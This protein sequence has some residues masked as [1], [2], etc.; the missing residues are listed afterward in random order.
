MIFYALSNATYHVSLLDPGAEL[1]GGVQTPPARRGPAQVNNSINSI[2]DR[3]WINLRRCPM[4]ITCSASGAGHMVLPLREPHVTGSVH[5]TSLGRH[6]RH[7][8]HKHARQ[9]RTIVQRRSS[10]HTKPSKTIS[11]TIVHPLH[12]TGSDISSSVPVPITRPSRARAPGA[13]S[14][15]RLPPLPPRSHL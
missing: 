3:T 15:P 8:T 9:V 14:A 1:G 7:N 5:K 13:A 10:R 4:T 6:N 12:G 11:Q 2:S